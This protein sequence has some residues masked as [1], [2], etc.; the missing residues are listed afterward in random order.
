MLTEG[1]LDFAYKA[2]TARD[3]TPLLTREE[4]RGNLSPV[5]WAAVYPEGDRGGGRHGAHTHQ[6]SVS[7]CVFYSKVG[8]TTAPIGFYDPRGAPIHYDYEVHRTEFEWQ[9]E[10]PFHQPLWLFPEAGDLICFPSWLVHTVPART[11]T[12]TYRVAFPI[13]L[14]SRLLDTWHMTATAT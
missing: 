14:Q 7:S 2:A 12:D 9:P 6:S 11:D 10:A 5:V 1:A 8:N 4:L 13:N 3:E